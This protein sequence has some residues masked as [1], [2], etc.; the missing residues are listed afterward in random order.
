VAPEGI[1]EY[2][3]SMAKIGAHCSGM[4]KKREK[5]L[6]PLPFLQQISAD[7]EHYPEGDRNEL[8]RPAIGLYLVVAG[9][10]KG[11]ESA[12]RH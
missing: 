10:D 7:L 4:D 3:W 6:G 8:R 5:V 2:Q 9:F 12:Q 11:V 1:R